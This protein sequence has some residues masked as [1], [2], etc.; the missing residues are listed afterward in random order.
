MNQKGEVTFGG[1]QVLKEEVEN[2][3]FF[4]TVEDFLLRFT[5]TRLPEIVIVFPCSNLVPLH[6]IN[7]FPIL[8]HP[9]PNTLITPS[10]LSAA[11]LGSVLRVMSQPGGG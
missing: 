6:K 3:F 5:K 11:V 1:N 9:H 7:F 2:S 10:H 4:W 8:H